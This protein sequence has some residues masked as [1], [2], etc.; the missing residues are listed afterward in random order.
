MMKEHSSEE[1]KIVWYNGCDTCYH[2]R[3]CK[4]T[5]NIIELWNNLT[6]VDTIPNVPVSIAF[7]CNNYIS[8]GPSTR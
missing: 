5:E 7:T 8:H 2:K 1:V 6:L 3:V 4:H